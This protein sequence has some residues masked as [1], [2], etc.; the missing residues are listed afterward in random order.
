MEA[1][2]HNHG[3][4]SFP[5][6]ECRQVVG[7]NVYFKGGVIYFSGRK[8]TQLER[9]I[10]EEMKP[11]AYDATGPHLPSL[12]LSPALKVRRLTLLSWSPYTL[13]RP[14]L[15]TVGLD[16]RHLHK[17]SCYWK[18]LCSLS[19]P[20]WRIIK[21]GGYHE[22]GPQ[23]TES[24]DGPENTSIRLQRQ[25]LACTVPLICD[26]TLSLS[27]STYKVAGGLDAV[28]ILLSSDMTF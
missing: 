18:G 26:R 27:Y 23:R 6:S 2:G 7:V 12:S 20:H 4:A 22:A 11:M 21:F 14:G 15:T 16:N 3:Q 13:A 8:F 17:W 28:K 10:W 5:G 19:G 1:F 24:G 9:I 25:T